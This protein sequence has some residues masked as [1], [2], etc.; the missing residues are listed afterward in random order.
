MPEQSSESTITLVI[1]KNN[2]FAAIKTQLAR[3]KQLKYIAGPS[4]AYSAATPVEHVL[5]YHCSGGSPSFVLRSFPLPRWE[6]LGEGE[7]P[8]I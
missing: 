2:R 7:S 6:R 3:Y 1:A 8:L 4:L 5:N